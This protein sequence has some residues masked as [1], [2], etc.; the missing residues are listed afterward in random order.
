MPKKL[1]QVS[2]TKLLKFLQN[3]GYSV[4]R[5]RGSHVRLKKHTHLGT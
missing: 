1:P 4:I 5:Q 3:L 2:G